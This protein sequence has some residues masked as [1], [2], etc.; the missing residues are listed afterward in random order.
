MR[1]QSR[2][3]FLKVLSAA[4][5]L[6]VG[7]RTSAAEQAKEETWKY[8]RVVGVADD[9]SSLDIEV[10]P[11]NDCSTSKA[12]ASPNCQQVHLAV[13]DAIVKDRVKKLQS[14]D[15][16][17]ITFSYGQNNQ[18][19]LKAF[20]VDSAPP[21][22]A[23]TR[24]WVVCASGLIL[25]L[26]YYLWSH[27]HP[28]KLILGEDGR[29]S[30]SKFQIA[31]WFFALIT[32]YLATV[33]FRIWY[34][35]CDFIGGVDIPKN[36]LLISG[37]SVLTFAGA[38]AITTAKVNTERQKP[39]GN[40]DPKDSANATPNL[41]QN[42]TH[43]DGTSAHPPQL[44]FGDFQMLIITLIAVGTYL[45]LV[46]S[47]LGTIATTKTVSLPDVD[48]TILAVFGLGHGAYLTK[49]AAGNVGES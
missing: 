23:F 32:T 43:N 15:R 20:C 41:L 31:L 21:V 30:N 34:A 26:I 10:S 45:T 27:L 44:D 16:I 40:Q 38:K 28:L 8:V 33:V 47:F 1:S 2:F 29:Y 25:F 4:A 37:M 5:L 46:F 14:G 13:Q 42:L 36:L 9:Q 35:G 11:F 39:N 49:K 12:I 17:T 18:N 24:F 22:S 6:I 48:T 7:A 19:P 3:S